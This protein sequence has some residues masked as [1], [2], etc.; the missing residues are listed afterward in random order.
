MK[1][2]RVANMMLNAV[3]LRVVRSGKAFEMDDLLRNAKKRGVWLK[4]IID[5][6]ASDGV[7]SVGAHDHFPDCS[8][9]LF[10]PLNERRASLE[11]LQRS[12]GFHFVAA[13]AGAENG[14]I[15][16]SIDENLDGSGVSLEVG[17]GKGRQVAVRRID[18]VVAEQKL[19]GP[20]CIKLDTHGFEL[21]VLEGAAGVLPEVEL[22]IIEV[23]NFELAPGC[24]RFHQMC[25]WLEER[26]FR[27]CDLADPMRRPGDGLLWQ[28]D[29]AFARS[30]GSWFDSNRF[31]DAAEGA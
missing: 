25:A 7:W 20:Y 9:L 1:V 6:G 8:F 23:Y 22:L 2:R 10:E 17:T 29:L 16:F 15:T 28:M 30:D 4:T 21:P 3:G 26:G 13:A 5:V 19:E 31:Y 11:A 14:T 24:L 12:R 18:D 27:C